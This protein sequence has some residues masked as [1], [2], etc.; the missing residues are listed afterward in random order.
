MN[1]GVQDLTKGLD[2]VESYCD[3]FS[4]TVPLNVILLFPSLCLNDSLPLVESTYTS[5]RVY[6]PPLVVDARVLVTP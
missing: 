1:G 4:V 2:V 6:S 5:K 3:I